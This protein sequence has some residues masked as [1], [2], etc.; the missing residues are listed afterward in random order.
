[1][2]SKRIIILRSKSGAGKSTFAGFLEQMAWES[3]RTCE[4]CC[5][6]DWFTDLAGNYKFDASQ[7]GKAHKACQEKAEELA[8]GN[9]ETIIV[10][11]VNAS[12]RDFK[13]YED[14]AVEYGYQVVRLIIEGGHHSGQNNHFVPQETLDRQEKNLLA[15]IQ[16]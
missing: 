3:D 12:P 16:L 1:M 9:C 10:A 5:A 13:F 11:N 4:V 7:L 8:I 15:S 14:L 6:D 2:N